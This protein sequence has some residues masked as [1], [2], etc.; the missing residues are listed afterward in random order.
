VNDASCRIAICSAVNPAADHR[1]RAAATIAS[2]P[3]CVSAVVTWL[4]GALGADLLDSPLGV[5]AGARRFANVGPAI[6]PPV[7]SARNGMTTDFAVVRNIYGLVQCTPDHSPEACLGCL[8]RLRD[9]MPA[10]F[11][12]TSGAQ[13][14]LVWCNL[15]Y[16]V[17]PF[18]DSS[19]VARL[20]APPAPPAG[21]AS[22]RNDGKL[23]IRFP[24]QFLWPATCRRG[25]WISRLCHALINNCL[26]ST[27]CE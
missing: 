7:G 11:N 23:A 25:R 13:V 8:G 24:E 2:R 9:Q 15:R 26:G 27:I 14:N 17:F 1:D 18:Y 6:T 3:A 16:E 22:S 21:G 4:V 19:P 5:P 12:G 20:V 10:L